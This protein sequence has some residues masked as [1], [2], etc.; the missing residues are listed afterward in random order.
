[1]NKI[2]NDLIMRYP[3]LKPETAS[4]EAAFDLL[5]NTYKNGGKVMCCG[6]GGSCADCDHIVGE[7]MKS[8]KFKR[9]PGNDIIT[10]L[11]LFGSEGEDLIRGLEGALPAVSLCG[12][13]ALTTA[14]LN[15]TNPLLTFAQQLYGIGKK[16]DTLIALTTSGNSP[17]C[18]YAAITA[19]AMDIPVIAFT[20]ADGGKIASYANVVIRAPERETYKIQEY[21]LPV[22]HALCAMLEAEFFKEII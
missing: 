10:R 2:L 13:N 18:I 3:A 16:G 7:L 12:H 9:K 22:Y 19:A 11:H 17:N 20:G 6:N 15:D 8:F 4:I 1:M 5:R 14:Y 21:H